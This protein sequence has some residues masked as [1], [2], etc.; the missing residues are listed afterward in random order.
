MGKWEGVLYVDIENGHE[1]SQSEITS[2]R[3]E[4][5]PVQAQVGPFGI[6]V[7]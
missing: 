6:R 7:K 5:L 4:S 2:M 3:G 1:N